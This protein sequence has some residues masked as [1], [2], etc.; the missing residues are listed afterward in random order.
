[1]SAARKAT[2]VRVAFYGR[3]GDGS[4]PARAER[5]LARQYQQCVKALPAGAV[6]AVFYDVGSL[7]HPQPAPPSADFGRHH[8]RRDGDLQ[9]L[10]DE[11]SAPSRRFDFVI[12]A[13]F[14]RLARQMT[15][16]LVG[17]LADIGIEYLIATEIR[18]GEPL[19]F[20]AMRLR[21]GLYLDVLTRIAAHGGGL[22]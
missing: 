12:S 3:V 22:R 4:D 13:E 20:A 7:R 9:S 17:E 8:V 15:T 1:M 21:T 16:A 14:D 5:S 2:P 6:T 10:F 11:A 18:A 19:R